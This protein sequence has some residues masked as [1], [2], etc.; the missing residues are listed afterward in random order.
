MLPVL[1]YGGDSVVVCG[2]IAAGLVVVSF[3]CVFAFGRKEGWGCS[4]LV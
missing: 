3:V 4:D 2:T 1:H